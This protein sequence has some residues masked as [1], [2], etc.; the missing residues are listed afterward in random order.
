MS[1]DTGI[2]RFHQEGE[3]VGSCTSDE[4]FDVMAVAVHL[5]SHEAK[6][7]R[8]IEDLIDARLA[9]AKERLMREVRTI[10]DM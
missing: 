6:F 3:T 4:D 1:D 5:S 10:R 8:D 9:N 2:L 7:A